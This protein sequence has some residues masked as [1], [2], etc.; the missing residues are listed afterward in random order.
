VVF[1]FGAQYRSIPAYIR[2]M[3]WYIIINPTAGGGAVA[4]LWPQIEQQLQALGLSYSVQWT[5]HKGHAIALVD[6]AIL[7]GHRWILG[8]G[9]DGT[10]H[11][12]VNGI[13]SQPHVPP[14]EVQYALL[15]VGTGNDW[16]RQYKIPKDP[17]TRLRRLLTPQ[18]VTQDVG[19]VQYH[20]LDGQPATCFFANVAGMAYDGYVAYRM[21]Q[22]GKADSR[23]SYLLA[24][25]RYLMEYTTAP[26]R[27]VLPDS[28]VVE[29]RFYTINVGICK[30]SG[31]GMQFVPHAI[32]DDGLLA[33][34]YA[35]HMSRWEVL[36]QTPRFYSGSIL[37]HPKVTGQQVAA[38]RI[39]PS[40]KD[41]PFW[42]EADGEF[43]GKAPVEFSIVPSALSVVL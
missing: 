5:T 37:K 10:N 29:D 16:A 36:L 12:I 20:T 38:L 22:D 1:Y 43:L 14:Q 18:I 33:L 3:Y 31:G 32:P 21:E 2:P 34:T 4:K 19:K 42:L 24:V 30:Y 40:E 35:R 41:I 13:L 25:A 26:A 39:E 11:E 15:P 28:S 6:K 23:L 27:I 9:G 8:I 17:A 7:E